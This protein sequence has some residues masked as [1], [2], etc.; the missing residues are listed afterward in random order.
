M[1]KG[2]CDLFGMSPSAVAFFPVS[3]ILLKKNVYNLQFV[4]TVITRFILDEKRKVFLI[5]RKHMW[6]LYK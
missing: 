5:T 2:Y 1:I 6:C 4:N 3:D